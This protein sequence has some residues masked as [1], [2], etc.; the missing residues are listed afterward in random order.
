M[1]IDTKRKTITIF[2]EWCCKYTPINRDTFRGR[3][4]WGNEYECIHCKKKY[5]TYRNLGVK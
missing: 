5:I 4:K 1:K 2:C 3:T